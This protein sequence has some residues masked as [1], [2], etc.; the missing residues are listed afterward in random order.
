MHLDHLPTISR[1]IHGTRVA[2]GEKASGTYAL[3][4]S[5]MVAI[6]PHLTHSFEVRDENDQYLTC[7]AATGIEMARSRAKA[8]G[9]TFIVDEL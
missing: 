9:A 2:R 4:F 6:R 1:S 7:G 8:S 3:V 5:R